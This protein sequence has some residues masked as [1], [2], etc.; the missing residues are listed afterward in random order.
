MQIPKKTGLILF[1][2]NRAKVSKPL[3]LIS[4]VIRW[5]EKGLFA[6]GKVYTHTAQ[7]IVLNGK[8]YVIDSDWDGVEPELWDS[9]KVGRAWIHVFDPNI[10]T[11]KTEKKY[12]DKAL[13]KSG[14]R[15]GYEDIKSWIKYQI[16]GKFSGESDVN[17]A[18]DNMLCSYFTGYLYDFKLWWNRSPQNLFEY[19]L[20]DSPNGFS[21][22]EGKP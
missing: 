5:F 4:T 2:F 21:I 14:K 22:T 13:N 12:I 16:T 3:S 8:L 18:D 9:W 17:K 11:E 19:R 1:T 7:T 20:I 6:K 15:Y 10:L